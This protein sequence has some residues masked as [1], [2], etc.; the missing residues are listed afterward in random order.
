M[1]KLVV[2]SVV[3]FGMS[4]VSCEKSSINEETAELD[5]MDIFQVDPDEVERPGEQGG[6]NNG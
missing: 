3:I 5:Q 4:L 2:L 6:D 1:K